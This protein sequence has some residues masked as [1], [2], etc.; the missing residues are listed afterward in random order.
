MRKV[1]T[2]LPILIILALVGCLPQTQTAPN[3]TATKALPTPTIVLKVP[4]QAALS[5][6]TGCT[7]VTQIPTPGPTAE[8]VYPPVSD[9]EWIKG[10]A[11][12][13]VTIIEYSDFQ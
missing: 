1:Y 7:A 3:A 2:I 5:L 11:S 10:P 13:K 4:T 8:S 12:A 6:D 9:T